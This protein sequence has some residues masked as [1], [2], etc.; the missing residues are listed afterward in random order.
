MPLRAIGQ[1]LGWG[2][3]SEQEATGRPLRRD[4]PQTPAHRD[5]QRPEPTPGHHPGQQLLHRL[6][7]ERCELCESRTGLQVHH[8]R[9]LADLDAPRTACYVSQR[10][11]SRR[12]RRTVRCSFLWAYEA[13]NLGC[14]CEVRCPAIGRALLTV[15]LRL[16]PVWRC[17]VDATTG[18][19]TGYGCDPT[20]GR[21]RTKCRIC[22]ILRRLWS[23]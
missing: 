18:G 1:C 5:H 16:P 9:K 10:P 8:V 13:V 17:H 14:S 15:R 2:P 11:W 19:H 3:T 6:L 21:R 20:A 23:V 12:R 4:P 7:A 22:P